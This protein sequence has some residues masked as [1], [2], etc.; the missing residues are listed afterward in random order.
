V[1]IVIIAAVSSNNV[2]GREGSL[3]W[4]YPVDMKHFRHTTGKHPIL[5][6]RK[7]FES[8]PRRPLPNRTNLI[9]T[10]NAIYDAPQ[11]VVV[12]R[13]IE[14]IRNYCKK[15][16]AEKLFILGGAEI[17]RLTL[18]IADEMVLT[19]I[20]KEVEGDTCFPEWNRTEWKEIDRREE[21]GLI[22]ATYRRIGEKAF[23]LP[24]A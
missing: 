22:F 6:G 16:G 11:G 18:P 1:E 5:A 17:Y 2:I 23:T 19:H 8:F 20:P 10:R 3:P 14:E 9:L 13:D 7:T 12:C 4:H 24:A 15:E 21:E